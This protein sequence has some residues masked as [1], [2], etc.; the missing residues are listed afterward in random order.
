MDARQEYERWLHSPRVDEQT[1]RELMNM[2]QNE[3]AIQASFLEYLS[4]GTAG[5][6]GIMGPG[7]ARM[8]GY[9]V[10]HATQGLADVILAQGQEAAKR[11][12]VIG[13]DSR[14]H[15][16]EFAREAA[17]VLAANGIFVYLFESLR[18][19]PELSFAVRH[20]HC[21]AGVNI[22][23]SHNPKVYNGYKAYWEDGAQMERELSDQVSAAM[24]RRDILEDVHTCDW[25]Q[26][27]REGKIQLIGAEVD[28]AYL[29]AV[30]AEGMED[31]I[32]GSEV[33]VVYSAFHGAG[34]RII[35]ELL[36]RR[37]LKKLW[38]EPQQLVPDGDF[39]TVE[40]PNPEYVQGFHLAIPLAQEKGA[41]LILGSDPD[42]DRT[43]ALV[44]DDNGQWVALSGNQIGILLTH[45]IIDRHQ[46]HGTMPQDPVVIKSIVSSRMIDAICAAEGVRCMEVYTGFKHMG[47][48]IRRMEQSGQGHTIFS[49]EE[50]Y[51]YL[52]GTYC[53]D[54]DA[55]V[56]CMLLTEMACFYHRQSKS[57]WKVLHELYEKYGWY[58]EDTLQI[59]KEGLEGRQRIAQLMEQLRENP[60]QEIAGKQ[61]MVCRDYQKGIETYQQTGEVKQISMPPSN[62]MY[63]VLEDGSAVVLRPSGTEPKIK[64]YALVLGK[65]AQEQKKTADALMTWG[66]QLLT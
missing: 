54:K 65:D 17:A 19:T 46:A 27:Q 44:R 4:F 52:K 49:Y 50:S 23:A 61:V 3:G 12:V 30:L 37:G 34:Y 36:K 41:Q 5:L 59:T 1:R 14:H 45:Y 33:G 9:T 20:L 32:R 21:I 62:V 13:C 48:A 25:Q 8:N 10:R 6:R 60:P 53:R 64:C 47:Q 58:G 40:S 7:T 55:P 39:P 15:S 18:P 51:G 11:G 63:F 57:L 66:K 31:S 2:A 38:P 24:A 56:T 26:A 43:A 22:T 29:S 35:P 42:A 28:E 16:A